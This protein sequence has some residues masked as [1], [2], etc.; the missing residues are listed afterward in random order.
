VAKAGRF[1][2]AV[3]EEISVEIREAVN[4]PMI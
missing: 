2:A 4:H 1:F 3:I